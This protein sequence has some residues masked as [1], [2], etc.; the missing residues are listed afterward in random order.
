MVEYG[1]K[2]TPVAPRR[3]AMMEIAPAALHRPEDEA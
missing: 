2:L 1:D 3:E